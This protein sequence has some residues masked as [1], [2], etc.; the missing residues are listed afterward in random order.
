M[1]TVGFEVGKAPDT[2]GREPEMQDT[3]PCHAQPYTVST[4]S[5]RR[6]HF[7]C[8]LSSSSARV[9]RLAMACSSSCV[10]TSIHSS[11]IVSDSFQFFC[12]DIIQCVTL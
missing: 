6:F 10:N 7:S 8:S 3:P 9:V 1:I 5:S 11:L 2:P 4:Y 12:S